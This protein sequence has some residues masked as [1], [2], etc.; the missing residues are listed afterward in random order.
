MP[1]LLGEF[2]NNEPDIPWKYIIQY[3][4]ETGID[5]TYWSL[6]GF[7]CDP[8]KDETFGIFTNNFKNVRHPEMLEDL[9]SVGP[10]ADALTNYWQYL[11]GKSY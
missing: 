3:L 10:P 4:K 9:I 7:K 1:Y 8:E 6:D 11:P 2:G 5:W